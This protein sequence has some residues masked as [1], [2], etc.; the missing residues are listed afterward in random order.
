VSTRIE[1]GSNRHGAR[2]A[3]AWN[4]KLHNYLGLYFLLF[5]WLFSVTGLL[6]NHHWSFA[7]FWDQRQETSVE[8][9]IMPPT[10]TGD[11]AVAQELMH[12]LDIVGEL[13]ETKRSPQGDQFVVNV[14]RPGQMFNIEANLATRR[15]VV[16]ETRVNGWGVLHMLHTFTGVK[17]NEPTRQR[18][19]WLMTLWAVS[20]DAL[21]VG[22]IVLVLTG[23]YLWYR[24]PKKR[25]PGMIALGLGMVCVGFFV[26]GLVRS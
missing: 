5:I 14:A 25:W 8:R 20:M 26:F 24:L 9:A 10:A 4:R 11:L 3:R 15:A 1:T 16:K 22:L 13:N 17:Q 6:L 12:Q 19:W 21:S 2:E 7:E 23:L 18:D